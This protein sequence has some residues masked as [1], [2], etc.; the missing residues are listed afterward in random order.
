MPKVSIIVPVYN[1]EAY[2]EMCVE[3][4]TAQTLKDIEIILVDDGSPDNSGKMCDELAKTDS[5]II[6]I[7]KE[8]GG[9]SSARNAGIDIAKGRYLGFVDS[10]DWVEPDM[11]EHLLKL[12][13]KYDADIVDCGMYK[14]SE[15]KYCTLNTADEPRVL[16]RSGALDI[17]F[18]ITNP[19]INY[20]VCDKIFKRELFDGQRFTEGIIFEDIDFNYRVL[21][22]TSCY[23]ES[24][25]QKYYYFNNYDGISHNSFRKKDLELQMVWDNIIEIAKKETPEHLESAIFNRKRA[26]FGLISKM[27]KFGCRENPED[28]KRIRSDLL[29]SV[30]SNFF[31]LMRGKMPFNRKMLLILMCI[32]YRLVEYPLVIARKCMAIKNSRRTNG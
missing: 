9:L 13:E 4:L 29:R 10:D 16:D 21:L 22:K 15:R 12:A 8:N 2:L 6:V 24:L 20:C 14:T 7:H 27:F 23:V 25:A 26:D 18:R 30:R 3:S 17:F 32:N 28:H 5:R 11:F 19:G 1:V 31:T